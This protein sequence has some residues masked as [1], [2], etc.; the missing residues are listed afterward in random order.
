MPTSSKNMMAYKIGMVGL[1][2]EKVPDFLP[3]SWFVTL[4]NN[5][6]SVF[7]SPSLYRGYHPH[8]EGLWRNW[9]SETPGIGPHIKGTQNMVVLLLLIIPLL[10]REKVSV[11]V[12]LYDPNR[13]KPI[14][15][16]PILI[17]K[18]R[19]QEDVFTNNGRV[20]IKKI[21]CNVHVLFLSGD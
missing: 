21:T 4:E 9:L 11:E 18:Q 15:T 3:P 6:T 17:M 20:L 16:K 1:H 19:Q 7:F 12:Q 8:L 5:W 10:S 14:T 2:G 13:T